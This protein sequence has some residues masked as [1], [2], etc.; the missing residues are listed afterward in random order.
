M[1]DTFNPFKDV[2]LQSNWYEERFFHANGRPDPFT[3]RM[4]SRDDEIE[5]IPRVTRK[6]KP[7]SEIFDFKNDETPEEHFT[8]V[9]RKVYVHHHPNLEN[10]T[11]RR[12]NTTAEELRD[13]LS[14]KPNRYICD[15][16]LPYRSPEK[17]FNSI[18]QKSYVRHI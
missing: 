1:T 7:M 6:I 4:R 13:I 18:Y 16:S 17:H 12:M 3:V 9:S 10:I 11:A 14:A 8:T 5:N 15:H 2:T